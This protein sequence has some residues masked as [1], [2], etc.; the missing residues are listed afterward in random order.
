[1]CLLVDGL[2]LD[3]G[4]G[5]TTPTGP[6]PLGGAATYGRATWK[7]ERVVSPEGEDA[8]LLSMS[9]MPLYTFTELEHHPVDFLA[10]NHF[11]ST[12]PS[13]MFTNAPIVQRWREDSVQISLVG[14]DLLARDPFTQTRLAP[15]DFG[16]TLL[17]VFGLA[18][19]TD[20]VAQLLGLMGV[21][22]TA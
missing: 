21:R 11:T 10:P 18:L 17:Q 6:I 13:S 3:V 4:F 20:E 5:A 15:G 19:A 8:W 22:D 16:D 7:T 9:D 2:L 1:M 14:L 12:H